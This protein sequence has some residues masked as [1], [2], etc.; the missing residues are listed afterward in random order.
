[1]WIV[2]GAAAVILAMLNIYQ[3]TRR[4]PTKWFRFFSLAM[5]AFTVCCFYGDVSVRVEA[6]DWAALMDVV[7]FMT[8][9]L[10]GL[11]GASVVINGI[12]LFEKK[13]MR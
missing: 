11:A 12:T 2:F 9:A 4:K 10:W 8:K 3:Y 5:T 7:P 6:G 1:M 13:E